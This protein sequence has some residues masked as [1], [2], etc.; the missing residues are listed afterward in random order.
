MKSLERNNHKSCRQLRDTL[1]KVV[2]VLLSPNNNMYLLTE[3]E[4]WM[5]K[6][7]ALAHG[8]WAE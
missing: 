3:W 4:G 6:Y 8:I 7:L 1:L 5:G 2:V